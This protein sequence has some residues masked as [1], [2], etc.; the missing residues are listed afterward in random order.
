MGSPNSSNTADNRPL[1]LRG[2]RCP[3]LS[4]P[5]SSTRMPRAMVELVAQTGVLADWEEMHGSYNDLGKRRQ[6]WWW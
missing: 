1:L 4:L 5:R 2:A 3:H 6:G